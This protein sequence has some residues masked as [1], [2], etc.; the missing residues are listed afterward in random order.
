MESIWIL[1][2]I[3]STVILVCFFKLCSDV[4]KLKNHF[5]KNTELPKDPEIVG[6]LDEII[7]MY[8]QDEF[9]MR[10]TVSR[11]ESYRK[12]FLSAGMS[13]ADINKI[14]K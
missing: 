10:L 6:T 8:K 5:I 1:Y 9:N 11:K 7:E 14:I 12:A 3:L 4:N 13:Y 2:V